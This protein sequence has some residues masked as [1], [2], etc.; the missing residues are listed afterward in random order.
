VAGDVL[1]EISWLADAADGG[2]DSDGSWIRRG[3]VI[4]ARQPRAIG[5][6]R[7]RRKCPTRT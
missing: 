6:H 2:R 5:H 3:R 7:T 1:L 4:Y